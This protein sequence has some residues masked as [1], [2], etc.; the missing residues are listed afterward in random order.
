M[1][2]LASSI[3][4]NSTSALAFLKWPFGHCLRMDITVSASTSAPRKSP[5]SRRAAER[6]DMTSESSSRKTPDVSHAGLWTA[7]L[8]A[9]L[10]LAS[11]SLV[12]RSL[13][14]FY[15]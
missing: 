12:L 2:S 5:S 11:A 13:Y 4:P 6:L 7:M 15:W 1:A 8:A 3:W 14:K 9:V 10:Y